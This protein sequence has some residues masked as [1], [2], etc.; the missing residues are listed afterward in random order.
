M[1]LIELKEATKKKKYKKTKEQKTKTNEPRK[2]SRNTV[3]VLDG[4]VLENDREPNPRMYV[5]SQIAYTF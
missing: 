3:Y 1:A 2:T 4:E 5:F